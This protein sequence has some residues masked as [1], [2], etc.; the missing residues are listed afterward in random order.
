M[1]LWRDTI[2]GK[3]K[4]GRLQINYEKIRQGKQEKLFHEVIFQI[5]NRE[6]MA[7]GTEAGNLAVNVLDEYVKDFQKRNPTLRVF[8]CYLH[9]DELLHIFILTLFLM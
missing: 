9:Q 6:D 3:E 7:V 4:T 2:P 5:G 8:S 1:M